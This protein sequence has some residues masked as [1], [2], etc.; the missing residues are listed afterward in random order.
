MQLLVQLGKQTADLAPG[1]CAQVDA[2]QTR[3]Y[4][5]SGLGLAISQKLAEAMGGQMW[6]ESHGLG[7]GSC[8]RWTIGCRVPPPARPP[9][10]PIAPQR[11]LA[12]PPKVIPSSNTPMASGR[13]GINVSRHCFE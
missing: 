3:R 5:G 6:A 13:Q 9:S 2:S 1:T 12:L 4:G 10:M 11:G 8:F 7:M